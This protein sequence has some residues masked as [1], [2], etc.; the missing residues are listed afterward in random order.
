MTPQQLISE[1]DGLFSLPEV[2]L[3]VRE[4]IDDPKKT[5]YDVAFVIN[6]DPNIS[7]RIL[8]I[9]NSAFFGFATEINTVTRAIAIMGL[10]Q[11]HD[12]VLATSAVN[13]FK[14]ISCALISMKDFW[15]H[16]VF[17]ATIARLLARKCNVIDC[18]RLF[19]CGILHD[20][21]HLVIY[22]KCPTQASKVLSRAKQESCPMALLE[23]EILGFD[24]AQVG[25]ELL[26]FWKL[27]A[28]LY[29]P[30][31]NHVHLKRD[32]QFSLDSSIIHIANI[33]ALQEE[34]HKTD[35]FVPNLDLQALHMTGLN[36][37]DFD[38]VK[39]EAK[40]NMAET[41]KLFFAKV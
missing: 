28:S 24:Y 36:Q 35:F 17:C 41:L 2:Y 7:A 25:G 20:L 34:S 39:T 32:E 19:V 40:K 23:K 11:I 13:T 29:E 16:S 37:E 6:Q 12:L 5:I 9:A 38:L 22:E 33:L 1:I 18:E 8:K 30:V 27:P 26:K 31:V 14:G 4:V 15:L 10:S 3:K 21:G